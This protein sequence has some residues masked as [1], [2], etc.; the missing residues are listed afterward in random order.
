[1]H[2]VDPKFVSDTADEFVFGA[3]HV[4]TPIWSFGDDIKVSRA[5][6]D[7][8]GVG[9]ETDGVDIAKGTL[10]SEQH[11]IALGAGADRFC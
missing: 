7:A 5:V 10:L 11:A 1:M 9:G 8:D 6:I 4:D 2:T 3:D